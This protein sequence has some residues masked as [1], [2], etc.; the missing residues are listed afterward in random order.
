MF[1]LSSS[2]I[3]FLSNFFR[4]NGFAFT[5]VGCLLPSAEN[6]PFDDDLRS[7]F[8]SLSKPYKLIDQNGAI[9][10]LSTNIRQALAR[11]ISHNGI[12]RL[13]SFSIDRIYSQ[14]TSTSVFS[15]HPDSRTEICLDIVRP[16]TSNSSA[17]EILQ[18]V[19]GIQKLLRPLS[20]TRWQI[21]LNHSTLVKAIGMHYSIDDSQQLCSLFNLLYDFSSR[22]KSKQTVNRATSIHINFQRLNTVAWRLSLCVISERR[23][24]VPMN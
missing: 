14:A 3:E 1:T 9:L 20:S 11:Y 22:P 5:P 13:R 10:T 17:I 18:F 4:L 21:L 24:N 7:Y 2:V 12:T 15:S 23:K 16:S 19:I 6:Y 8:G